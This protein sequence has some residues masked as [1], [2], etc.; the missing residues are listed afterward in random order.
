MRVPL[1]LSVRWPFIGLQA[2]NIAMNCAHAFGT[3]LYPWIMYDISGSP[4]LMTLSFAINVA[5]L[6]AGFVWGGCI[7]ER[8]GIRNTAVL[9]A[10][11]CLATSLLIAAFYTAG[12][13][14]PA[15]LI[16]FAALG[17]LLEG[18]SIIALE[19]RLP[20]IA[21]LSRLSIPQANA[22]DGGVDGTVL[23][24]APTISAIL[25]ATLGVEP[26]VWIV[27]L[28]SFACWLCLSW[29]LPDFSSRAAP[30]PFDARVASDWLRALSGPLEPYLPASAILASFVILQAL[31]VPAALRDA[32]LPASLLALFIGAAMVGTLFA[33]FWL[34]IKGAAA[35]GMNGL[36]SACVGLA[37]AVAFLSLGLS[38]ASL[39]IAGFLAGLANGLLTPVFVNMMQLKASRGV[40]GQLLGFSYAAL[41]VFLPM[42]A[43]IAG[44]L[45]HAMSIEAACLALACLLLLA[46]LVCSFGDEQA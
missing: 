5:I 7:A 21:R 35:A 11:I 44:L 4:L 25:L 43:L 9:S 15:L 6:L 36:T 18:P 37:I 10:T 30:E 23:L 24:V 45:L 41:L 46:A 33:N 26:A 29:S 34:A 20:E 40:G 14:T 16:M 28:A 8:I 19:T 3:V 38:V 39:A 31:I 22:I 1:A 17:V 42:E 13:L 2:S 27:A 12:L 32:G